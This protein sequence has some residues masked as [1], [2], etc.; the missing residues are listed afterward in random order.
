MRPYVPLVVY[1]HV[2]VYDFLNIFLGDVY[3]NGAAAGVIHSCYIGDFAQLHTYKLYLWKIAEL[4]WTDWRIWIQK[5]TSCVWYDP[6]FYSVA[7]QIHVDRIIVKY[8]HRSVKNLCRW[9]LI[10]NQILNF[11]ENYVFFKFFWF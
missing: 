5:I 2:A 6:S 9:I 1:E 10:H 7:F 8:K 11:T 3:D 4:L